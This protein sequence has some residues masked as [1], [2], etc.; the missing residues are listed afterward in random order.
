M[1]FLPLSS[2]ISGNVGLQA[3]T[4]TTRAVSHGHVTPDN[5][6]GWLKKEIGAALYLGLAMGGLVGFIA[7]SLSNFHFAFGLTVMIAQFVSILTAGLT[8][9]LAP[10]LFSFIFERDAGK[11]GGPLETAIQDI[12]GS[13]AM[14]VLSY[15]ILEFFGPMDVEPGDTCGDAGFA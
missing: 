13:F 5:L 6:M 7:F 11:W 8:G 3:S 12:V 10:L 15:K 2:A 9:T 14:V 1:G 4:L